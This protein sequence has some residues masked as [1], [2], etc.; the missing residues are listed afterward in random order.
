MAHKKTTVEELMKA[1]WAKY[2]RNFFTR[3]VN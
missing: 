2:G 1:H 3:F